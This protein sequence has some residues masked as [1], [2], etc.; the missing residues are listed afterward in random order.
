MKNE[1]KGNMKKKKKKKKTGLKGS[2]KFLS[3]N[4]ILLIL[5]KLLILNE[6]NIVQNNVWANLKKCLLY[7]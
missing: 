6:N 3:I 2:V 1:K 7:Y 5:M 4:L